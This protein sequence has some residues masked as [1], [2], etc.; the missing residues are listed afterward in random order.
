MTLFFWL[1]VGHAIADYPLQGDFLAKAKN[2]TLAIP[3]IPWQQALFWHARLD[4]S[5]LPSQPEEQAV[6]RFLVDVYPRFWSAVGA[7]I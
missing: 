3:G 2:Y 7:A 1:L 4:C 6:S 5:H